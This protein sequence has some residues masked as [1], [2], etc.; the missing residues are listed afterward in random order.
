MYRNVMKTI[1]AL[2]C[3]SF[4]GARLRL[5]LGFAGLRRLVVLGLFARVEL[6]VLFAGS[7]LS[8]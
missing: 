8:P 6:V 3:S 2:R 1:R 4:L 5:A 7:G